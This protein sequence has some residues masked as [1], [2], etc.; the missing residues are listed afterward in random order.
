MSKI[1]EL[2]GQRAHLAARRELLAVARELEKANGES[3]S[4]QV[5]AG[6]VRAY[7]EAEQQEPCLHLH[8]GRHV[9]ACPSS[10]CAQGGERPTHVYQCPQCRNHWPANQG[11]RCS[12]CKVTASLVPN[13]FGLTGS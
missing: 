8:D 7:L 3:P 12:V 6:A 4:A 2:K 1:A 11:A 13:T 5:F 10:V 9:N